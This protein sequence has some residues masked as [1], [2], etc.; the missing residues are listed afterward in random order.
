MRQR[1]FKE[2]ATVRPLMP[3]GTQ[4]DYITGSCYRGPNN[5]AVW[6]GGLSHYT[7]VVGLPNMFKTELALALIKHALERSRDSGC[8]THDTEATLQAARIESR[9][10]RSRTLTIEDVRNRTSLSD[11][12]NYTGN[13]WINSLKEMKVGRSKDKSLLVDTQFVDFK[14]GKVIQVISPEINFLDSFSGLS[15]D[16]AE[17]TYDKFSI[18]DKKLN[19]MALNTNRIKNQI[20][21]QMTDIAL[22]GNIFSIQTA[23]IGEKYQLDPYAPNVRKMQHL[24]GNLALKRVPE[25]FMF[26]TS[27]C[28][29]CVG[30]TSVLDGER[31]A[32]YPKAGDAQVK[33]DTDLIELMVT[34]LRNKYG[35]SGLTQRFIISQQDGLLNGLT[36][37]H[38]AKRNKRFGIGGN[39][40]NYFMDL[41]PEVELTRKTIRDTIEENE[42]LERALEINR[43]LCQLKYEPGKIDK[44]MLAS[45]AKIRQK[46]IDLGYDWSILL[47]TR[48]YH[49]FGKEHPDD[50]P[51]LSTIDILRMYHGYYH[52]YWYPKTAEEMKLTIEDSNFGFENS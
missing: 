39:N 35:P 42:T 38:Y 51:Y 26:L 41:L 10:T 29:H 43:W 15:T 6:N 13:E 33:G 28:W 3:T 14:S 23:H 31:F 32:E 8:H 21:E 49:I 11:S 12:S 24:K 1:Y 18:G 25:Q 17:E 27:G 52:P 20:V 2:S 7:G 48:E 34:N 4:I 30:F 5:E 46:L 37:F 47:N 36:D 45:P 50:K 19:T 44:T 9:W 22:S 40:I 16:E